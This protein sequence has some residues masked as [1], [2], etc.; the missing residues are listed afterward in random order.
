MYQPVAW[1][2]N[3]V[4]V[5]NKIYINQLPGRIT[6]SKVQTKFKST[7]PV[8][9]EGKMVRDFIQI[10]INQ[11]PGKVTWSEI[12]TKFKLPSCRER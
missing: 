8:A 9:W 3:M 2:G 12:Q 11:L 1:E 4:I 6:W 5:L 10:Y 7:K